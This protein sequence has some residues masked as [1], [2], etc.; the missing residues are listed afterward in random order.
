M[1]ITAPWACI[2]ESAGSADL[3]LVEIA[4]E[5]G[6]LN[7]HQARRLIVALGGRPKRASVPRW[8]RENRELWLGHELV[9]RVRS[10]QATRVIRIFDAFEAASWQ[11]RIPD[12][13]ADCDSVALRDAVRTAN[14]GLRRILFQTADSGCA[15]LWRRT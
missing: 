9:R 11:A 6:M 7:D 13:L 3:S 15:V 4:H 2:C 1:P 8:N 10:D 12:P 5:L 14:R